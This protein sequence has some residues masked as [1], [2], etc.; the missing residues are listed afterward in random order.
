MAR[1]IQ[2]GYGIVFS[3]LEPRSSDPSQNTI[4]IYPYVHTLNYDQRTQQS[5]VLFEL[6]KSQA[7][8]PDYGHPVAKCNWHDGSTKV[9]D[10]TIWGR[11]PQN[12][13]K[14]I[15]YDITKFWREHH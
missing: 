6:D 5:F 8:I 10:Q 2:T 12:V 11:I 7:L 14:L 4:K 15:K 3:V 9:L 1:T 13:Q